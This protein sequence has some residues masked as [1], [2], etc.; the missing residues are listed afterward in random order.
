MVS[1]R[2]ETRTRSSKGGAAQPEEA[3]ALQR[4]HRR[5]QEQLYATALVRRYSGLVVVMWTL[6]SVVA[7]AHADPIPPLGVHAVGLVFIL[8]VTWALRDER[9]ERSAVRLRNLFILMGTMLNAL[10]SVAA[11]L[12]GGLASLYLPLQVLPVTGI[13][14]VNIPWKKLAPRGIPTIIAPWIVLL[15]GL[16]AIPS[17]RGQLADPQLVRRALVIIF[18]ELCAVVVFVFI[19]DAHQ[20]LRGQLYESRS[21]GRYRLKRRVGGGGMGEIWAAYDTAMRRDVALK[22]LKVSGQ[23]TPQARFEREV[24][25]LASLTHPNT[26]RVFDYATTEDGLRYYA[27]ELLNGDTLAALVRREGPLAWQRAVRMI[28]TV[29]SALGEAHASGIIHRDVKPDNVFVAEAGGEKDFIKVLD[30]GIAHLADP[31][32]PA[33]TTTG[34]A[35]GTPSYMSPEAI[36][37]K[38]VRPAADVYSLGATLYFVLTATPP[39][40]LESADAVLKAHLES[41]V[42]PPS[43]CLPDAGIPDEVDEL[44]LRCL[45]KDP[46]RRF[47]S[48]SELAKALQGLTRQRDAA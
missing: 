26:V 8:A 1:A 16:L 22:I 9:T 6:S 2:D 10:L 47:Q 31:K 4:R 20:R 17:M 37:G 23:R 27:M 44:C 32:R 43:Q 7:F 29:A 15:A 5:V 48:G 42:Q 12:S 40:A 38:D 28:S 21:L 30:F 13:A 19:A 46:S 45:L 35:P 14:V 41:K 24:Q 33:L 39:H 18:V 25:A 11:L 34:L 36:L 3:R